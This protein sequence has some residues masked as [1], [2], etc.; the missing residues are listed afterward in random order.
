MDNSNQRPANMMKGPSGRPPQGPRP[1][2]PPAAGAMAMTPKEIVGILRRHIWMILIFT[3]LGTIIGGGAW[4]LCN[5][6]LPRYTSTRAIDVD[7]P[8]NL[9]PMVITGIQPQ[10]DIYYQFRFTKATLVKQQSML[11]EL[12]R[13]DK[14]RDTDWFKRYAK[15]DSAGRLIGDQDKAVN[16]AYEELED[17][18]G[19]SAPRDNNYIL[20]SMRC[21]KAK[22]AKLIVDEMVDVF[23]TQQRNLAQSGLK[24]DLAQ[25]TKQRDEI[26]RTLDQIENELESIRSGTTFARLN[27]GEGQS[28]R[29][30]MDQRLA[31]LE[32][33]FSELN[34][35]KGRLE[36]EIAILKARAEAPDFDDR[37]QEQVQN[38]PTSRLLRDR[39]ALLEPEL[40][41]LRNRFGEDHR[42]VRQ[43]QAALNEYWDAYAKRQREIGN[44]L[45]QSNLLGAQEDMV[46]IVRQLETT[47]KQ[48]QA[49]YAEYKAIDDVRSAYA[50]SERKRIETTD[51]LEEMNTA[52]EKKKAQIDDPKI[53]KLYSTSSATL[54]REKSFPNPIMFF[55]G[56]FILGMLAGLGLAF[57]VELMN[58]LL[59]TPSD[60]MRHLK[61][62][63]MGMICH[64]DDDDDIEGVDLYHVVRQAPYSI[65]SECY[66]QLRTNLKL[67]GSGDAAKK[68]LLIT[69]AQ[70]E[71]G[72]TTV[73][74]NLAS[75]LLAEDRRVLLIDTNFR[76]PAANRLFP[77]SQ[78]NGTPV[79]SSYG[80]SNYLMGQCDQADQVVR[81][82]GIA[83][84]YII[85]CGP[86]PANPAEL[87][88]GKNMANLLDYAKSN[89]DHVIIDG[90][91]TIV[92]DSKSLAMQADGTLIVFNASKTHR[93][94]AMR[95]LRE[96]RE[97]H[98]D[99]I[100]TVLLG[101]KSRKGG[102][103]RENYRSYQDYQKVQVEQLV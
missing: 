100:G 5:R 65:M 7:P 91:A 9:D 39:I 57:M 28:F 47:Q 16:K 102:Y 98:A 89:F 13:R 42:T 36:G 32:N 19:A 15:V 52:I 2:M 14:V 101:V 55:P 4:F 60:V 80:L 44:I 61:A 86:L 71:D 25:F 33:Q 62:P 1:P 17:N 11:E 21:A 73:A 74:V 31:D 70:A 90:P 81:E 76:R 27:L 20:V 35:E 68:T 18:L 94:E 67:S 87:L 96:M 6:Y 43:S 37:V 30:Y 22:E 92:T 63:L 66:R 12:L 45:R 85:D 46:A 72:K 34:S 26:Q 69:S 93:G 23:L 83:G 95:I 103:F 49:A 97:I 29:D 82:S 41:R 53:S 75:A 51:L 48:L 59:R 99:I 56:G 3:I 78:P 58:D 84:L 64:A 50:I 40:E 77:H 54:P 38:D 10:K 88:S 8:I 24:E 79:D